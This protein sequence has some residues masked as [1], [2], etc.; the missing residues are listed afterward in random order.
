MLTYGGFNISD[1]D[2][3]GG[4]IA[5][6]SDLNRFLLAAEDGSLLDSSQFAATFQR[7]QGSSP[8]VLLWDGALSDAT[9]KALTPGVTWT[10][11]TAPTQDLYIG[12]GLSKFGAV[13][14]SLAAAGAGYSL[15]LDYW[16]G[17]AF[18]P[19]TEDD[20]DLVDETENLS[21]PDGQI[22]FTPPDDWAP[23]AAAGQTRYWVRLRTE[24]PAATAAKFDLLE[25]V[26]DYSSYY[27][28]GWFIDETTQRLNFQIGVNSFVLGEWIA[29]TTSQTVAQIKS[30][31]V[32]SP[33]GVTPTSGYLILQ[34]V[35]GG[36]FW[37]DEVISGQNGGS[38]LTDGPGLPE[39]YTANHDGI[40]DGSRTFMYRR[41][42]GVTWAALFNLRVGDS[43][44]PLYMPGGAPLGAINGAINALTPP[45]WPA[46]DL[47]P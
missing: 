25:P 9:V 6:A 10:G 47:F 38:A 2:A 32:T 34:N 35:K 30:V 17:S 3:H 44:I 43:S 37:V 8:R 21:L 12:R 13:N 1:L 36:P 29:G 45:Y 19:L 27:G 46:Y 31:A 15:K 40:L 16:N 11:I 4:W 5:S 20:N 18:I 42:D 28:A 24:A 41:S 39:T 7:P 26:Y 22:S 14:I 23:S 33:P